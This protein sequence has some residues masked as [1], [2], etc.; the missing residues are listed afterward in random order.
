MASGLKINASAICRLAAG[1]GGLTHGE[2]ACVKDASAICRLAAGD[3]SALEFESPVVADASAIVG[4][5]SGNGAAVVS[6]TI[7]YSNIAMGMYFNHMAV[8]IGAAKAAAEAVAVQVDGDSLV[9]AFTNIDI[10]IKRN[11]TAK[12]N[13][14]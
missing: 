7:R 14:R 13:V 8:R 4:P 6:T 5:A 11:I 2:D 10:R 3:G 1:N 12:Y 9:A